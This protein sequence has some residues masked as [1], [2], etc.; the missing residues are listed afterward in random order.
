[1]PFNSHTIKPPVVCWRLEWTVFELSTYFFFF[2]GFGSFS[3]TCC[4]SNLLNAPAPLALMIAATCAALSGDPG[5]V[6]TGLSVSLI[7][8]FPVCPV[9]TTPLVS[10]FFLFF[11]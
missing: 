5:A 7:L 10:S 9:F 11:A 6:S 4:F 1:M 2:F 3:A 8:K